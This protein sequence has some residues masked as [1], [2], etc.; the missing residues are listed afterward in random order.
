MQWLMKMMH[1]GKKKHGFTLVELMIVVVIV[2]ILA[3]VALALYRGY[4][5]K[6]MASEAK[7]GL[8]TMRTGLRVVYAEHNAYD[9]LAGAGGPIVAG[10]ADNIPGIDPLDLEGTYFDHANYVITTI[11]E[12]TFVL[13]CTG[14]STSGAGTHTGDATGIVTILNQDGD[15]S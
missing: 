4:M 3:A 1:R 15:W 9:G 10:P 5:K 6:A 13:T 12:T 7:A 11:G 8:G 2:G 14:I